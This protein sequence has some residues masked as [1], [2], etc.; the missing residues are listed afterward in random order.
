MKLKTKT[1]KLKTKY[2]IIKNLKIKFHI[3]NKLE[4]VFDF[5]L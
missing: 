4:D 1:Q 2:I 3:I 5:F